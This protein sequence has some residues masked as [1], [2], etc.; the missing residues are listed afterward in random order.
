MFLGLLDPDPD[1]DPPLFLTKVL[2]GLKQCLQNKILTQNIS[3]KFSFK[4]KDNV[5]AGK[6][7]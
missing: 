3:K 2:S 5:P 6:L 7:I 1:P 4:T